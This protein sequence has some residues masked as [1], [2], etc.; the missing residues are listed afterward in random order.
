MEEKRCY[1]CM[2]IKSG[3]A[4]CEHCGYD[5]TAKNEAH[6]LPAGTVLKEQ[7]MI[8]KVLGQGGFGITY[9]GWDMYLDIPVAIKEYF[10]N[11]SVM[12]DVSVSTEVVSYSGDAG[13][14]FRNNKERFMREAKMLARFSDVSEIVHVKNFFL[15]NNTAYIVMEYVEGIN[16]K[17]MVKEHGGKL[18]YEETIGILKPIMEALCKVHKAGL[19][20]R[21][22]SPDNIMLLP[23]GT[24]KLLD[25]G[26]VRDVGAADVNTPLT[27]STEAIIKQGYAPIE[28]YQNRGSLGPWT[29]VYALCA[30]IYYCLTGEVPMD[31]PGR[32]LEDEEVD[33]GNYVEERIAVVLKHGME[34][35][36]VDRIPSVDE[37]LEKLEEHPIL[38][39]EK[40]EKPDQKKGTVKLWIAGLACAVFVIWVIAMMVT[41]PN[42]GD[43]LSERKSEIELIEGKCG[44]NA[45]Y[46]FDPESQ[47]LIISGTGDMYDFNGR[48]QEDPKNENPPLAERQ[49]VPWEDF[50]EEIFTVEIQDGIT[51]IG[52][53]AFE[54]HYNL[55]DI[56]IGNDV[57]SVGFQ[58]F[59]CTNLEEVVFPE[60]FER[61]ENCA[62]NYCMNLRRVVFPDS[63]QGVDGR[64]FNSC[65][66]L[67]VIILGDETNLIEDPIS[68]EE[69]LE[70]EC[71]EYLAIYATPGSAAEKNFGEYGYSCKE[72]LAGW[73]G[74][75]V[76]WYIDVDEKC[77]YLLG[78][79]ETG[80]FG[81]SENESENDYTDIT[82]LEW[83]SREMPAY[84]A[85]AN[86]IEKVVVGNYIW[87][88]NKHILA[89]LNFMKEIDFGGAQR[90]CSNALRGCSSLEEITTPEHMEFVGENA[91]IY[92]KN[93]RKVTFESNDI[94]IEGNGIFGHTPKL[95]EVYF[96]EGATI[97]RCGDDTLDMFDTNYGSEISPN[98]AFYVYEGSDAEK[99][100]I[101]FGIPY[102]LR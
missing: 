102:E 49:F 38:K 96:S 9:L 14:R 86:Q 33:F 39:P 40:K 101:D 27:A 21:D 35:R 13:V 75:H 67:S 47:T 82:T 63:F 2:K 59:L 10:P 19:V 46:T 89:G 90:I 95:E 15:A 42:E 45:T 60:G 30:T 25:F 70:E 37:L 71:A 79:G 11:S 5:D 4:V 91:F 68:C 36:A 24:A 87:S 81:I 17:Q 99:Y 54:N 23:D 78:H 62:F 66:S 28:Q 18:S 77:L 93:L 57:K 55:T 65:C 72:K 1:G 12:R 92:C 34:L 80:V 58:A 69:H 53:N 51:R 44:E 76:A 29:D 83:I 84:Q 20:H 88:L 74:E 48:W 26:A 6:Q 85:Y 8:G 64:M 3:E 50:K 16:L 7:Y 52:E 22:I 43:Y 32:L 73:C 61:L 94:I 100:A 56:R 97:D 31:A 98:V 41:E